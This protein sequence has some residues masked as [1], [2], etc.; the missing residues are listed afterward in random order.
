MG[1]ANTSFLKWYVTALRS[2]TYP[3][4]RGQLRNDHG[5][6]PLGVAVDL[7]IQLGE[8]PAWERK[9]YPGGVRYQCGDHETTLIPLAAAQSVGLTQDIR[10]PVGHTDEHFN[11]TFVSVLELSDD[12]DYS[13]EEI[14]NA[15]VQNFGLV[16]DE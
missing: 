13:F 16:E 8:L 14:A 10:F 7:L 5:Y 1:G 11:Y 4:I 12:T 6:D 9:E 2:G 3:Q 15:I